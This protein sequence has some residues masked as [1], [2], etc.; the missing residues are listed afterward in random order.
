M[1]KSVRLSGSI[2]RLPDNWDVGQD[3]EVLAQ[4]ARL[5]SIMVELPQTALW[6]RCGRERINRRGVCTNC[7]RRTRLSLE[8]FAGLREQVFARDEW[9]QCCGEVVDLLVHHRRPG[10]NQIRFLILLCRRCHARVHH[11]VRPGFAFPDTLR[12]LWREQHP[13][14]PEQLL[15]PLFSVGNRHRSGGFQATL[16]DLVA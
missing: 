7:E 15:L 6:C 14:L 1:S 8:N 9:A 3:L 11:T 13:E 16:F 2:P 4:F 10:Q 12:A 5:K